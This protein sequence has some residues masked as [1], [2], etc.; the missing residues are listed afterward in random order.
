MLHEAY[1]AAE[2]GDHSVLH[3]LQRIFAEPYAEHSEMDSA[4]YFRLCPPEMRDLAGI[5]FFS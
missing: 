2:G 1:T 3:R 4:S 5:S